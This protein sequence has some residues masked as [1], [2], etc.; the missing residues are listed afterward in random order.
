MLEPFSKQD[1]L[2]IR[3]VYRQTNLLF[4][5]LAQINKELLF[6]MLVLLLE[7]QLLAK[8]ETPTLLDLFTLIS[9]L[10]KESRT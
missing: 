2:F 10:K 9:T 5:S 4:D 7:N 1:A 8:V 6:I 3:G